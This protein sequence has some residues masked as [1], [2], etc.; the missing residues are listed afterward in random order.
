MDHP[1]LTLTVPTDPRMLSVA[2]AFV[3]AACQV[4]D[5]EKTRLHAVVLA[6]GEAFS[7]AIRHAHRDRPDAQIQIQCWIKPGAIE[8]HVHDEGA[9]FDLNAVP[10]LNPGELRIGGR[11]VYLMRTLMDEV[12]CFRRN[13]GGNTL[14]MV[15][16]QK[17][18]SVRNCG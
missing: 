13:S 12:S 7:N 1:P 14:R 10:H 3:E 6:A 17:S 15:K 2:R 18:V 9:P 11:G 4:A 16:Y 5:L 8:V